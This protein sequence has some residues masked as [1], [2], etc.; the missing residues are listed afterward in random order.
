MAIQRNSLKKGQRHGKLNMSTFSS[1]EASFVI[2]TQ[3]R[4]MR[5]DDFTTFKPDIAMK[6]LILS[7]TKIRRLVRP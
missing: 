1:A 4:V 6:F 3:I 7:K 2:A 5:L